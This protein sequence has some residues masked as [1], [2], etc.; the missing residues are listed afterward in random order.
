MHRRHYWHSLTTF[1]S[2]T[3]GHRARS[4]PP[5]RVPRQPP[6]L[7][8]LRQGH[9]TIDFLVNESLV[10][11]TVKIAQ[12]PV[13]SK[14]AEYKQRSRQIKDSRASFRHRESDQTE[15]DSG[16]RVFAISARIKE[17]QD[18][19]R[20]LIRKN[21]FLAEKLRP[22]GGLACTPYGRRRTYARFTQERFGVNCA[23][24][25]VDR[26]TDKQLAAYHKYGLK[27][28]AEEEPVPETSDDESESSDEKLDFN[29]ANSMKN[30]DNLDDD[31]LI[32]HSS[33]KNSIFPPTIDDDNLTETNFNVGSMPSAATMPPPPTMAPAV[34]NL[35]DSGTMAS[36]A[37]DSIAAGAVAN[38]SV[39]TSA[40]L[41]D[42][43][44]TGAVA[45][46]S[47]TMASAATDSI[48]TAAVANDSGTM[49]PPVLNLNDSDTMAS[50]ATDS[51][52]AG[53]VANDSVTTSANLRDNSVTTGASGASSTGIN[54]LNYPASEAKAP[55]IASVS[56]HWFCLGSRWKHEYFK[57]KDEEYTVESK[58]PFERIPFAIPP[59]LEDG[60]YAEAL[61]RE[62]LPS[63]SREDV[64]SLDTVKLGLKDQLERELAD[65]DTP[66]PGNL[67]TVWKRPDYVDDDAA[68]LAL[69]LSDNISYI[70][71][72][73][74]M[75]EVPCLARE[76]YQ[77]NDWRYDM[78]VVRRGLFFVGKDVTELAV[79]CEKHGKSCLDKG[80]DIRVGSPY[81]NRACAGFLCITRMF[82]FNSYCKREFGTG[83][84]VKYR[85]TRFNVASI[86]S[87]Y[88]ALQRTK[89]NA[90]Y[91]TNLNG[92]EAVR[93][94][95]D[96]QELPG[97]SLGHS[98]VHFGFHE[99]EQLPTVV[100][101]AIQ[102]MRLPNP[103][104][105]SH[106]KKYFGDEYAN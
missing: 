37:T 84:N 83:A 53:A 88:L 69:V 87:L 48:A 90:I 75:M 79:K 66:V 26:Y 51:I 34:L 32:L 36:A 29:F 82:S 9:S 60:V 16:S 61:R 39:T 14:A 28:F 6:V 43:I 33:G 63:K 98:K 91:F 103:V 40:N 86:R 59:S 23:V 65:D 46:D 94:V 50:A 38:D 45:N 72:L 71:C 30:D 70:S 17:N 44:A 47:G 4:P 97:G 96:L 78:F 101:E 10:P 58:I 18:H 8:H 25:A 68:S 76:L 80:E 55:E 105:P 62:N 15:T 77:L 24:N 74:E 22:S 102:S 41:R 31:G 85:H 106:W 56:V 89:A 21:G 104:Y 20:Q 11:G 3:A 1:K 100:N 99:N 95:A 52:A 42:S 92:V 19:A 81:D 7:G 35:N 54:N 67:G 2:N 57:S 93:R 64:V 12:I 13:P 73:P 49:A 27:G 5:D